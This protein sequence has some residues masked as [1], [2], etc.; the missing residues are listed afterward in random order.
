MNDDTVKLLRECEAGVKMGAGTLDNVMDGAKD[1]RLK[2]ILDE[3]K[4]K[5]MELEAETKK[6]LN[7]YKDDGKEPAAMAK[8]M[9]KMKS[10]IKLMADD[11]DAKIADLVT[12]GCDMGIKTLN[13]YLNQYP[14]AENEVKKLTGEIILAEEALERSIRPYL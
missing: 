10:N 1:E 14:A 6:L 4:E 9:A 5:H 3:S 8:M 11:V 7:K 12:D 13:R 2:K